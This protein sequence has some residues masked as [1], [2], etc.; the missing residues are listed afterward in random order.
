M[1]VGGPHLVQDAHTYFLPRTVV[2]S[3]REPPIY[4][5][6]INYQLAIFSTASS[7][8]TRRPGERSTDDLPPGF[9]IDFQNQFNWPWTIDTQLRGL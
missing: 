2:T 5:V 6:R 8:A 3:R 1:P 4:A 7:P 9:G